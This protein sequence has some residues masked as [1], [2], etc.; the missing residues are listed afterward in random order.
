LCAQQ[1]NKKYFF[2]LICFLFT[3][4]FLSSRHSIL[5]FPAPSSFSCFVFYFSRLPAASSPPPP[6][7]GSQSILILLCPLNFIDLVGEEKS[8]NVDI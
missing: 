8:A 2:I 6:S 5:F 7:S 3:K 1:F 4:I